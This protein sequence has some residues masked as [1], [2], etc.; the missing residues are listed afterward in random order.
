MN[1]G[2]ECTCKNCIKIKKLLILEE[3]K[4]N[5]NIIATKEDYENLFIG[6]KE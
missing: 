4:G 5:I 2:I 1:C 6:V 3:Q